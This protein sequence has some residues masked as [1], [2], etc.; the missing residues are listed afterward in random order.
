MTPVQP[1]SPFVDCLCFHKESKGFE[2]GKLSFASVS[3]HCFGLNTTGGNLCI[4]SH[5]IGSVHPDPGKQTELLEYFLLD[6]N[7]ILI[8]AK[9]FSPF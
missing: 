5:I 7:I 2:Q 4:S 3:I 6:K 9:L 1:P 8:V